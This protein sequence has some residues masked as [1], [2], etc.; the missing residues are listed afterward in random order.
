MTL[1]DY[2]EKFSSSLPLSVEGLNYLYGRGINQETIDR[3]ELGYANEYSEQFG[4]FYST[5]TIPS[6]NIHGELLGMFGRRIIDA[7]PK[8]IISTGYNK[9]K[10][11][12][13]LHQA[14]NHILSMGYVIIT[15]G[16]FDVL[17]LQQCGFINTV[18][19][20]GKDWSDRQVALL[21]RFTDNV[22]LLLDNDSIGKKFTDIY[23]DK[24]KKF[25]FFVVEGK[26]PN[27][28]KDTDEFLVKGKQDSINYLNTI[29]TRRNNVK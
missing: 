3:F 16:I 26:F 19:A 27:K 28:Y 5:V 8:H 29:I 15:E 7:E 6:R 17:M 23:L 14:V 9:E 20:P 12:L 10:N 1:E 4:N 21:R 13:G 11:I 2:Q 22:I 24:F 18:G 25:G